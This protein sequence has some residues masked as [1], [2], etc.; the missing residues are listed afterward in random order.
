[1]LGARQELDQGQPPVWPGQKPFEENQRDLGSLEVAPA[2]VA[3]PASAAVALP[4]TKAQAAPRL[5]ARGRRL[6]GREC[7]AVCSVPASR[8]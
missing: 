4:A 3:G 8:S 6:V 5:P 1:M 7:G 2:S